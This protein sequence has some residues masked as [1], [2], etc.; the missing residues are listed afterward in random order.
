MKEQ[1]SILRV[2]RRKQMELL[3]SQLESERSSFLSHWRDLSDFI[4]PR[5]ARFTVTDANRGDRRNQK[6]IDSSAT[7]AAGTLRAGLMSGITSPARPWFRLTTSDPKMR[8][9]ASVKSWLDDVT[10]IMSTIYLKSNLYNVLP[11]VYGDLGV[12]STGAM[13]IEED[14]DDVFRCYPFP[15]G[16][17]MLANDHKLRV[18]VFLRDFRMTVRQLI[19]KFG[20]EESDVEKTGQID[21]SKFSTNVKALFDQGHF[22]TWVDVCHIVQP[23]DMYNPNRIESQ[24]KKFSSVYYERGMV[25]SGGVQTYLGTENEDRYLEIKGYDYFPVLAPRW[26][27][28]GEDAY[29]TDGPAMKALGDIKSLQLMQK[30]KSQAVEKQ[31]NPP[32][33]G[34]TSMKNSRASLIAGDITFV[35]TSGG[36]DTFRPAHE[37]RPDLQGMQETIMDT[38]AIIRRAFFED[39]FL[40]LAQSDRRQIT[41]REIDVRQEEKL[42]ALGPVLEQLNQ[43][44]LD[45]LIDI[46]FAFAVKQ[47][48]IPEAPPELQGQPL[49]VEYI[50]IMAQAQKLVGISAIERFLGVAA[51][52]V[53][54]SPETM[55]K[56]DFDQVI[57]EY[58]DIL[59][60]RSGI[61]RPDEQVEEMRVERAEREAQRQQMEQA[62]AMAGA[63]RNLSQ[64]PMEGNTALTQLLGQA[65]AP[66]AVA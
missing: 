61:V 40:M 58:A 66:D 41:A 3:R 25:G 6:I 26:E 31:I 35:D 23:N 47:G 4:L 45:P 18:R 36:K 15:V 52:V 44:L 33:V 51:Q 38:R 50:S 27:V 22:E 34:P 7:Q 56:I 55:D 1:R 53:A 5:R 9:I 8:D 13:Y 63:A 24:F 10:R 39:L 60:I 2:S 16:S 19:E 28:T 29:G 49:K 30:R 62:Q 59:S 48:R 37:V 17:Y 42:L 64:A 11:I 21:W 57:D 14:V 46:T 12:F 65:P 54:S 43:D 32:M 20:Y